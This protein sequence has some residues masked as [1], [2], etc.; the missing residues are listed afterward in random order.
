MA[1]YGH[2]FVKIDEESSAV[3]TENQSLITVS[4][5]GWWHMKE[6]LDQLDSILK[7]RD[8]P[9]HTNKVCRLEHK[10]PSSVVAMDVKVG[11]KL[12]HKMRIF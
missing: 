4:C 9:Q 12:K 7:S 6:E 5:V 2:H 3:G 1:K 11:L 10:F 8:R